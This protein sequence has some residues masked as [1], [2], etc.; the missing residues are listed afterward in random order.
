MSERL[1]HYSAA[2]LLSVHSVDPSNHRRF[3]PIGLWVSVEGENDWPSWCAGESWGL[4]R[5]THATEIICE[6]TARILRLSCAPHLDRFTEEYADEDKSLT[7]NRITAVRWEKLAE[8]YQ[9][10]IIAPYIW[11]RR[12]DDYVQWYYSWDCASGCIWDATAIKELRPT[13]A[14]QLADKAA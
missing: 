11:E 9:G 4:D 6:P 3:K 10:I 8:K 2:P 7:R 5:L 13:D 1:I 12:L 14:P